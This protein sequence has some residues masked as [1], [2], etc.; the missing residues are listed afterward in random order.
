MAV[1]VLAFA[2]ASVALA[3]ATA[4]Q[5]VDPW[6]RPMGAGP[7]TTSAMYAT[8]KNGGGDGDTLVSA[9]TPVAR[10]VELHAV[11][12]E[13]DGMM[14]MRPVKGG[15][16]VPAHGEVQLRPGGYHIMLIGL[17]Q[18]I[19]AGDQIPVTLKFAKAG[20]VSVIAKA[21]QRVGGAEKSMGAMPAMEGM[22]GHGEAE[23]GS[24]KH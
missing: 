9:S 12:K 1:T 17:K 7:N 10:F 15:I 2:F 4:M 24:S 18:A 21:E 13:K 19:A 14:K 5:V 20:E 3:E 22:S 6:V 23:H 16:K 11:I 8:I